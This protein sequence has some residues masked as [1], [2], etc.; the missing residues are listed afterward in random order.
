[1]RLPATEGVYFA[2]CR[3]TGL[4]KIGRSGNVRKRVMQDLRDEYGPSIVPI[5]Y[6]ETKQPNKI[7]HEIHKAVEAYRHSYPLILRAYGRKEWPDLSW[8]EPQGRTEWFEFCED[9]RRI[10]EEHDHDFS[11]AVKWKTG[12]RIVYFEEGRI[13]R[14]GIITNDMLKER[15]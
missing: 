10:I 9:L 6:V 13:L 7:E 5:G 11:S 1:M 4:V 8:H 2:F 14:E 12:C 3:Y 15:T